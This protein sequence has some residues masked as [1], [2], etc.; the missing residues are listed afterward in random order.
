MYKP[1][2]IKKVMPETSPPSAQWRE[3]LL[4]AALDEAPFSGWT[5]AS[6]KAAAR[7]AG[8]SEGEVQLAA[9]R[10][11][12]DL[13]ELFETQADAAMLANA[14]FGSNS[15]RGRVKTLALARFQHMKPHREA[16]RRAGPHA[17]FAAPSWMW[18]TADQIWRA[19]GD[20]STDAN[21]YSK[22]AI[23]TGVLAATMLV[24]LAD[25]TDDLSETEAFLAR[26][27]D[28]VMAFEK[29]KA[30]AAKFVPD[31]GSVLDALA[32]MRFGR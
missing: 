25:E 3:R 14:Q 1:C 13:L 31:T 18:R 7:T 21:F 26:R 16:L 4:S 24:F 30:A 10:G 29:A 8:L 19:L 32:R 15:L 27:L 17:A 20:P 28:G 22:R 12:I 11:A 23:L 6:L 9:P 5:A 2:Y